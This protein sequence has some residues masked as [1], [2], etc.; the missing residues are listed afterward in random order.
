M[1]LSVVDL[2][3]IVNPHFFFFV[4]FTRVYTS[5]SIRPTLEAINN[6]REK[7][8]VSS[9]IYTD[10]GHTINKLKDIGLLYT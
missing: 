10:A 1:T 9:N 5:G 4:A 6:Q 3:L 2:L 7:R 8:T